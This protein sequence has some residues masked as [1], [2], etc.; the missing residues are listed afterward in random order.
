MESNLLWPSS[1]LCCFS[2]ALMLVTASESSYTSSSSLEILGQKRW[3]PA[4]V[5][6]SFAKASSKTWCTPAIA[7]PYRHVAQ[8]RE[9][10]RE[11]RTAQSDRW[12]E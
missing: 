6:R 7:T 8:S 2:S 5:S 11:K 3:S 4:G 12:E 9:G 10:K 1:I